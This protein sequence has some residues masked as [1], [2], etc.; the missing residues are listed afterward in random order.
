[1]RVPI[2]WLREYVPIEMPLAEL[3][4]RFSV[5]SGVAASRMQT[6]T[7]SCSA[8]ASSSKPSSTRTPTGCS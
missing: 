3:A 1:M 4:T 6:G 5:A 7:S 2:S 8:S